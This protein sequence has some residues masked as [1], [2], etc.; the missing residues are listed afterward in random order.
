[1]AITCCWLDHLGEDILHSTPRDVELS[2]TFAHADPVKEPIPVVP[3]CH[4]MM[5]GLPTN[6]HGQAVTRNSQGEDESC[7]AY[8]LWAKRLACQFTEPIVWVETALICCLLPRGWHLY[9]RSIE[10]GRKH[11]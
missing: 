8:S 2:K 4:Y 11:Q 6:I 5:G 10:P 9:Q 1:M 3:T 7:Q